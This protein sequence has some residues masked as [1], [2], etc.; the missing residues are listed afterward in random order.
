LLGTYRQVVDRKT[1]V[2][3]S[4]QTH[5]L[6]LYFPEAEPFV[7]TAR[8]EWFLNVLHDAPCPSAILKRSKKA[9]VKRFTAAGGKITL[10]QRLVGDYYEAAK[11]SVGLPV[12][13]DSWAVQMFQL[14]VEHYIRLTKQRRELEELIHVQLELNTDYRLLR[15]IPGIGPIVALTILAEGG[16]LR[17]FS[18][19]RKFLNYCGLALSTSQSGTYRGTPRLSKRGNAR[20]RCAFWMAAK[21]AIMQRRNSFRRKYDAYVRS[22]PLDPDLK[23]K[24]YTAVAA[25]VARVVFGLIKSGKEYRRFLEPTVPAGESL[26][27]GR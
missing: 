11:E 7:T 1:R 3:H 18:H 10:R 17:R 9:F 23:R 27:R 20:L 5:Y 8:A 15:T 26:R 16:D 2:Y 6:P 22:N 12:A 4:L 19:Y 13:A 14:T 21:A 24:A 25:K